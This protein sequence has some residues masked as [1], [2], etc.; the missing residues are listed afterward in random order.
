MSAKA[1]D[2]LISNAGSIP[3]TGVTFVEAN[4]AADGKFE[5]SVNLDPLLEALIVERGVSGALEALGNDEMA[6]KLM[7]DH[8]DDNY[9]YYNT[10]VN[11]AF[12][13]LGI[14]YS[15]YL[16][17]GGE[18]LLDVVKYAPDSAA[19]G[20]MIPDRSQTLHDN[21]LGN[22]DEL[23]IVDKFGS[24]AGDIFERIED[25]GLGD[26]L[27]EI[28][29]YADGRGIYGGYDNQDPAQQIAFDQVF[30]G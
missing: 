4:E 23:S 29:N 5:P 21:I 16:L 30:F 6:F 2:N 28:G 3:I 14:A 17:D 11:D 25:A 13:D 20:N 9:S 18:R 8:L 24:A 12:I 7:W 10:A 1:I 26:I 27:G 22:F 19:D 15:N